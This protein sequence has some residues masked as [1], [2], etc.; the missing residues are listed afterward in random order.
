ML[1]FKSTVH[2]NKGETILKQGTDSSICLINVDVFKKMIT[3]NEK[4]AEAFLSSFSSRY[5]EAINRLV[6]MSHKHMNGRVAE[7]LL[8]I[9]EKVYKNNTF[10]LPLSRQELA[11]YTG[12]T[13]ESISR[14]F[15][16][17]DNDNLLSVNGRQI[18][19][20]DP[21]KLKQVMLK[22]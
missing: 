17:F 7:A 16:N 15:K 4:F 14:I 5:T 10:L 2:Y 3:I 13:K 21:E 6:S 8:Y 20:L 19:I 12:T 22:G 11:E 9:S 18:K 1:D